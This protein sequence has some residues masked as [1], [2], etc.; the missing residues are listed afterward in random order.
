MKIRYIAVIL[1]AILFSSCNKFL[2]IRP[3]GM[4]IARTGEDYRAL[5]T[6]KYLRV[7]CDRSR[8]DLRTNDVKVDFSTT[9][10]LNYYNYYFCYNSK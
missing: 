3:T 1:A 9:T 8:T 7:P 4:V 5:L 10:G 6:E 2:D